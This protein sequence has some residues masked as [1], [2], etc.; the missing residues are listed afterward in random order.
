MP[1]FN[2]AN[3]APSNMVGGIFR[4]GGADI[5]TGADFKSGNGGY[6]GYNPDMPVVIRVLFVGGGGGINGEVK[7]GVIKFPVQAE[8]GIL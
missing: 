4:Q 8:K 7:S 2:Q 5:D 1:L 3:G 6:P